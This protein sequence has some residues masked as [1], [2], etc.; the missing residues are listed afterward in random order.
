VLTVPVLTKRTALQSTLL[1]V[2][3]LLAAASA[4]AQ[5]VPSATNGRLSLTAGALGSVFQPDYAGFGVPETAPNRLYG[6][7]AFVDVRFTRWIQVEAEGRW[8]RFNEF[9]GINEDNYLIGPRLPIHH[10]RF[11]H[12]T[13]YGKALVGVARMNFEDNDAWGRFTDIAYG[14]GVDF[15]LNKRFSA[16]GDFEYQQWPK[17]LNTSLYPYGASVG[18]GYKIF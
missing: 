14:G 8:L 13:P 15:Q 2:F 1:L 7:G 3:I 11:L 17:W 18:I 12:A 9:E 10:F 6:V 4:R 5:V 16:R